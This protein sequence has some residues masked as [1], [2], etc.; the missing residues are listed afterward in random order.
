MWM[1]ISPIVL[2]VQWCQEGCVAYLLILFLGQ[3]RFDDSKI[4]DNFDLELF[5]L[6]K[7]V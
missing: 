5:N 1:C 7:S 2:C 3:I 6:E 4:F